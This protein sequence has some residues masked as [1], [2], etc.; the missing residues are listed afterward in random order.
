MTDTQNNL[1]PRPY[2]KSK[3]LFFEEQM[4]HADEYNNDDW[5][6]EEPQD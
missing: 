6:E 3:D 4:K 1:P 2:V 5:V